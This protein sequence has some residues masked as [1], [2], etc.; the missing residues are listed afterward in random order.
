MRCA[1]SERLSHYDND[2][3]NAAPADL[4]NAIVRCDEAS[5]SFSEKA[6]QL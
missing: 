6:A 1:C 4:L 5:N 3:Y 2:K